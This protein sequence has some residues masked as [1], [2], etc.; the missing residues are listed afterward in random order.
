MNVICT[1]LNVFHHFVQRVQTWIGKTKISRKSRREKAIYVAGGIAVAAVAFSFHGVNSQGRNQVYAFEELQEAKE[2][3]KEQKETK[4]DVLEAVLQEVFINQDTQRRVKKIGTSFEI[5][6]VGQ[7]MGYRELKSHLDFEREGIDDVRMLKDESMGI[8]EKH[9]IMTDEDYETLLKIV[10]AE[11]GGEDLKGK[12]LVANVIFNRVADP[13][14]PETVTEVVWQNVAGSPQFSPTADGRIHT[15]TVSDET[16]EAVNRA[17]DG[18]D[19]SEG[20]LFFMEEAYADKD[21]AAW[22][23]RDLKLLFRYGCHDFYTYP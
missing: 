3:E 10:E 21:N 15:V 13:E 20:A 17:I 8:S 14:F 23:K 16:V 6:L 18:E 11:A 4:T 5:I 19:Y 9:L 7:R 1:I 2:Q 22:F 12:I